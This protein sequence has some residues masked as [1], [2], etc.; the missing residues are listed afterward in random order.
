[1]SCRCDDKEDA[2]NDMINLED[3]IGFVN[4]AIKYFSEVRADHNKMFE[5]ERE[6]YCLEDSDFSD[7]ENIIRT[8]DENI[9]VDL[10]DYRD[11][12]KNQVLQLESAISE[13]ETED[14]I[15]HADDDD[16]EDDVD[17]NN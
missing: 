16:D 4:K 8:E 1:M 10:E 9:Q 11:H 3:A 2:Y 5:K 14:E 12:L 17:Y 6:A 13:M 7:I 15:Y